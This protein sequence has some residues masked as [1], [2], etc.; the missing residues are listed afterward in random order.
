M[1][2]EIRENIL[3]VSPHVRDATQFKTP[4]VWA[5]PNCDSHFEGLQSSDG[6]VAKAAV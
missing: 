2:F 6:C 4:A 1:M 3:E 5:R